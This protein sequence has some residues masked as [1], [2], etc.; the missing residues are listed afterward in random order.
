MQRSG[1]VRFLA[2]LVCALAV[3]GSALA[4]HN[5]TVYRALDGKVGGG[6]CVTGPATNPGQF[7]IDA[8]GLSTFQDGVALLATKAYRLRFQVQDAPNDPPQALD[9]GT[10]AGMA[11]YT[12]TYTPQFGVGHWSLDNPAKSVPE[13]K[14]DF[15]AYALAGGNIDRNP[16]YDNNPAYCAGAPHPRLRKE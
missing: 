14:A 13:R 12:A 16:N 7:R 1:V 15:Q 9:H 11:G 6:G 10:V 2:A 4:Q 8:D 3:T 5:F